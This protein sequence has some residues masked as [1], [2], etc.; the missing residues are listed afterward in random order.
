MKNALAMDFLKIRGSYGSLGNQLFRYDS[1]FPYYDTYPYMPIMDNK[2]ADYIL[3]NG[4]PPAVYAP[5]A[6]SDNFTW[7]TIQTVN[8]GIDMNFSATN[9]EL[10]STNIPATPMICWY[11]ERNCRDHLAQR[12]P[13]KMPVT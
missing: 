2:L 7:E 9:W 8:A 1:D 13:S 11:Q 6:V 4:K 3:G 10:T 12:F 5:R